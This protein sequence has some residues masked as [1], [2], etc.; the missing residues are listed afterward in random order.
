MA[1]VMSF[2]YSQASQSITALLDNGTLIQAQMSGTNDTKAEAM[3]YSRDSIG[4]TDTW[5][6][7]HHELFGLNN[8]LFVLSIENL[9][10][11]KIFPEGYWQKEVD[12]LVEGVVSV[13]VFKNTLYILTGS[14][15]FAYTAD[16]RHPIRK[17]GKFQDLAI[18]NNHLFLLDKESGLIDVTYS[19]D[20]NVQNETVWKIEKLEHATRL[21]A[22]DRTLMVVY[23]IQRR[24][25]IGEYFLEDSKLCLNRYYH[26]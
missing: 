23:Y 13:R 22:I 9:T 8:E 4:S 2:T 12:P 21:A 14:Q 16:G 11:I 7:N 20:G 15:L 18:S 26:K 10:R 19:P 6:T 5:F 17:G 1:E 3:T 24:N 25:Y